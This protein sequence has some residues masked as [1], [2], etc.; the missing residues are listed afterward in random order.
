MM[1][2]KMLG[3][4]SLT[5]SVAMAPAAPVL[6]GDMFP[7]PYGP[8]DQIGAANNLSPAGVVEAAGLVTEGKT[9]PL[10]IVVSSAT[11][12]F[13]PRFISVTVLTPGQE[14][15]TSFGS[16]N[17]NYN[18]DIFTGWL[19]VATQIDGLGHLGAGNTFYNNNKTAD[20]VST[21]GLTK[22]GIEGIPPI[23][24]RGV[25]LDI[26]GVRGV[27]MMSEGDVITVEDIEAAAGD[28][29]VTIGEGDVVIL[30]TGWLSLLGKD[31]Q[32]FVSKEPGLGVEA[33]A[34][35]A[36]QGVV[37]V[38]ADNWG[39]EAVPHA[40][41]DTFFPTHVELLARNGVYILE[42]IDTRGLLADQVHEFLFVLGQARLKGA[43][44][45][46]INPVAI[47]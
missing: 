4:A 33:A 21:T 37:A 34:W 7:S 14:G 30:H 17:G 46:I 36:E 35:L 32:R 23:V 5:V 15:G 39:L 28:A 1:W 27:E 38:G 13:P 20:F 42:N 29:G 6:A 18:D 22:L 3:A 9:Y 24:T 26:A 10:G 19:G 25:M 31:D 8:D 47:R 11:P 43:V 41:P 40:D 44:Q 12:A 2:H 45:M 16:N